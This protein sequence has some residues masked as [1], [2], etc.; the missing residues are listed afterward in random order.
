M[1]VS[2]VSGPRRR[3]GQE[4]LQAWRSL[5]D[6]IDGQPNPEFVEESN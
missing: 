3:K 6:A 4:L 2:P 1:A 5:A